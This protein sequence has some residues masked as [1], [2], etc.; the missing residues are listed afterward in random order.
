MYA[1]SFFAP[2]LVVG[3]WRKLIFIVGAIFTSF[4]M[5]YFLNAIPP[6]PL[7]LKDIGIYHSVV[8]QESGDY[9]V[10]YEPGAWYELWKRSDN[11]FHYAPG[12]NAY[13][14]SSVFAPEGLSTSVYHQ[15]EYFDEEKGEWVDSTR[16][17]F[18]IS[19]GRDKG[20]RSFSR[21]SALFEG[22]WRCRVETQRRALVG[23]RKF[24][25]VESD[26]RPALVSTT[27]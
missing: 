9:A 4:N 11:T 27:R 23:L 6:V 25:I 15:W 26:V 17:S 2:R 10:S 21:K 18:P 20:Y 14:F 1:L 3:N 19:G 13:C 22:E 12:E 7:S 24:E 5:L 16:V 8:R